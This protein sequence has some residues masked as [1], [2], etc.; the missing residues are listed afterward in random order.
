MSYHG[1]TLGALSV[2]GHFQR[3]AMY[4]PMLMPASHV[5]PCYAYR[6]RRDDETDVAYGRRVAD[7]LDAEILRVGPQRVAAF[8]AEPVVGATLGCVARGARAT[9]RASAR[10]ATAHGVLFIADEVMCGMGRTGDDVRD[11]R[12]TACARTSSRSAR[13]W[14]P[15]TLPIGATMASERVVGAA[16]AG[17]GALANG[18]TY[19]SHAVACA[20]SLAVLDCMERDRL[21]DNVRAQGTRLRAALDERFGGHPHVGDIRGRGL[22]LALELV[23]DRGSK[24]P[25][26]VRA[27]RR[28]DQRRRRSRR[29]RLLSVERDRR[30]R[31]RRS[32][33]ARAALHRHRR[34]VD[35]IVDKLDLALRDVMEKS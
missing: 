21:L 30:R 3:R 25:S 35:E 5:S 17:S 26:R 6:F 15:A 24:R 8:V 19:M 9:S 7:E 29:P 23:E 31:A 12:T 22:F 32:C 20:G 18:H 13:A 16:R 27:D 10:S 4:A 14:A 1:N 34:Q 33:A 2:G 11:R 28:V